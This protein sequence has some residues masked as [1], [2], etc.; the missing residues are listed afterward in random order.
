[1]RT[2]FVSALEAGV[3]GRRRLARVSLAPRSPL[4][5]WCGVGAEALAGGDGSGNV[6]SH[7]GTGDMGI[8]FATLRA[9]NSV[10]EQGFCLGYQASKSAAGEP[11]ARCRDTNRKP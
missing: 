2:A 11:T 4:S 9:R 10:M 6:H 5:A 7:V 3:L 8:R 1:M